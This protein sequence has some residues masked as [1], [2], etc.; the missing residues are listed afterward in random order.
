MIWLYT[1]LSVFCVS[2]ISFVGLFT[3]GMR[4]ERLRSLLIYLVSFAAGAL[5]GDAFLHIIPEV[6]ERQGFELP[7]SLSFLAGIVL[8]LVIEKSIHLHQFHPLEAEENGRG[9]TNRLRP[10]VFTNLVGDAIHNFGDGLIIGASYL[11]SV[12]VGI[13][14]S[15]AVALHEIPHEIGNYSI[16]VRGGMSRAKAL[17]VNFLTALLA[18]C[19]ALIA[20]LLSRYAEGVQNLVLPIAAGGFIYV[21]GSDLIPEL[22]KE[23]DTLR[24][25]LLQLLVFVGGIALM[26]SLLLLE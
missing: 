10:Y 12:P 15:F 7:V 14:T 21:A 4:T 24:K 25:V 22:H 17:L 1:F 16:L 19:G 23:S 11:V 9:L 2:L 6:V 5:F 13:A 8:F 3:F 18:F 20:L 26:A